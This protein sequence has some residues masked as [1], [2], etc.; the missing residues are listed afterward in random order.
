MPESRAVARSS[1]RRLARYLRDAPHV[2][3]SRRQDLPGALTPLRITSGTSRFTYPARAGHADAVP[4][5]AAIRHAV[6]L[7]CPRTADPDLG[8]RDRADRARAAERRRVL[9]ADHGGAAHARPRRPHL[10]DAGRSADAGAVR[11]RYHALLRM[12]P[13]FAAAFWQALVRDA[14]RCSSEFRSGFIGKAARSISS[15]AASIWR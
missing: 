2:D 6:R 12:I 3:A 7:R 10:A 9:S 8:R 14:Y 1:A 5:R 4:W 13:Q 11:R 15:G